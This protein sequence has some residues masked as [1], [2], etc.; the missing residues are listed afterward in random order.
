M[1]RLGSSEQEPSPS[2]RDCRKLRL[3]ALLPRQTSSGTRLSSLRCPSMQASGLL[4][5]A[6]RFCTSSSWQR[7]PDAIVR[8]LT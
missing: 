6:C 7:L 5:S 8:E 4:R 3:R 1:V 2:K